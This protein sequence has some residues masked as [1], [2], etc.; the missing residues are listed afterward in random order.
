MQLQQGR[1]GFLHST[2]SSY[3]S[4]VQFSPLWRTFYS[5]ML[6][7]SL[8]S[9][10]ELLRTHISYRT[11]AR[12]AKFR[13]CP[14]AAPILHLQN[15]SLLNPPCKNLKWS[16][17]IRPR[18]S[19]HGIF[20]CPPRNT[21]CMLEQILHIFP[22]IVVPLKTSW[23]LLVGPYTENGDTLDTSLDA[24]HFRRGWQQQVR[25]SSRKPVC[26]Y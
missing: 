26:H 2:S 6:K 17:W 1:G 5:D 4:G 10:W 3:T 9:A 12:L 22:F 25:C 8:Y 19:K 14:H 11:L 18:G 7:T 13:A 24:A 15:A 21:A 20:S 23:V 16:L